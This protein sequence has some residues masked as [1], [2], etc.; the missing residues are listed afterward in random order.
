MGTELPQWASPD[1]PAQG[2][3]LVPTLAFS[4]TSRGSLVLTSQPSHL[5]RAGLADPK[6]QMVLLPG[7]LPP[8]LG[9][10]CSL[11]LLPGQQ[12]TWLWTPAPSAATGGVGES[13]LGGLF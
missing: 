11:G 8:G 7:R 5:R 2:S 12:L 3:P 9:G 10:V 13:G 4:G 6:Q 1:M